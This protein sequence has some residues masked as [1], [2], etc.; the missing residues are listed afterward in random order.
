[1]IRFAPAVAVFLG[2][3]IGAVLRWS[4]SLLVAARSS[5][6]FPYS[7]LIVNILGAML[8]GALVEMFALRLDATQ[9]PRLFLV[10]GILGGFT[11]FSAFALESV[12]LLER[13]EYFNMLTYISASVLG[14]IAAV[15]LAMR[16][17]RVVMG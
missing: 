3:G 16:A 6:N 9:T 2:G 13:G 4:L 1:M 10:T 7:T 17:V 5:S 8:I 12:L 14:T 11:T 15:L